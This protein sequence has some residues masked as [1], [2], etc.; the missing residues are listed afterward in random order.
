MRQGFA[1]SAELDKLPPVGPLDSDKPRARSSV[2]RMRGQESA[3][4]PISF[5]KIVAVCVRGE[6]CAPPAN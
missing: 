1:H 2:D 3:K 4:G 5:D 6:T